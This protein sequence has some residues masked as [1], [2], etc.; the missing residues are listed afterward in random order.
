MI[1]KNESRVIQRC[2][3]SVRDLIDY[4]VIFDTGSTDDTKEK[5][6]EILKDIPGELHERPWVDFAHNR[7][8]ALAAARGRATYILFI[9][10]DERLVFSKPFDK[11]SLHLDFYAVK[12]LGTATHYRALLVDSAQD[13]SWTGAMHEHLVCGSTNK[14]DV[15]DGVVN[16]SPYGEG[17]RSQDPNKYTNDAK[18]LE[19]ALEKDPENRRY[20]FYLAQS[21]GNAK[22]FEKSIE[23]YQK[24]AEM[25]GDPGEVFWALFCSGY[26]QEVVGKDLELITKSYS[27]AFLYNP[28]R[29]EPLYRLGVCF[30]RVQNYFMANLFAKLAMGLPK[31][32]A[33]TFFHESVYDYEAL[34]LFA[35]TAWLIG[36]AEDAY[37]SYKTISENQGVPENIKNLTSS[38]EKVLEN[39]KKQK[40]NRP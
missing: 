5:I 8:E 22:E 13:W 33:H 30:Y 6:E 9:D 37:Q 27:R 32:D 12:V 29:A 34:L 25:G 18:V 20:I 36:N 24:R 3:S 7:N 39:F 14:G 16:I 38:N 4:W 1:V 40:N 31:P 35:D 21:Y 11:Q 23:A 15:L 26:L 2:L 19:R 17:G 10:A 28:S